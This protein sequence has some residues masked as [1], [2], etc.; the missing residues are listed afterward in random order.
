M[1][2]VPDQKGGL[3]P[4][5]RDNAL[6]SIMSYEPRLKE[7]AD[8]DLHY[9]IN[10]DSSDMLP[11]TWDDIAKV[12]YENHEKYD[13]F[14]VIHG[15]DTM[16]YT[17]SGVSFA[18]QHPGKP[19]VFTGSQ[20]PGH[21]LESDARHNLVNAVKL[22]TKDV[23]EIMVLF[24]DRILLGVRTTKVS[25]V[26]LNAFSSVNWPKL[27]QVG[28]D[29]QFFRPVKKKTGQKPQLF[30]GFES[31]IIC[32]SLIPGMPVELL[33]QTLEEGVRGVILS[34]FGTGNIPHS[35]L[36]FLEK[37]KKKGVPVVIRSQCL[38]GI[39]NMGVYASGQAALE[40]GAIEAYDMSREAATTKL[41]WALH[42]TDSLSEIKAIMHKNYVGEIHLEHIA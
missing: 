16:A 21:N 20:I 27:G 14:V 34:S 24:G 13:G 6:S 11:K 1:V 41:M 25:H 10:I 18:L 23:A 36:M 32:I 7:I 35:Y 12:I 40:R 15:T 22:A 3:T 19:I 42:R 33:E 17:S 30:P 38:E 5:S 9:V 28:T 31:R 29:L 37:A 2:M 39:T 4:P 8:I 26:K